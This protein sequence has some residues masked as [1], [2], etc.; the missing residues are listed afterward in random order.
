M[1]DN[2]FDN[3]RQNDEYELYSKRYTPGENGYTEQ[4][5]FYQGTEYQYN[6]VHQEKKN[7]KRLVA[8]TAVVIC[9]ALLCAGLVLCT[10]MIVSGYFNSELQ[11]ENI[12][13]D[14]VALGD[15]EAPESEKDDDWFF[16]LDDETGLTVSDSNG[17]ES[18][19]GKIGDE[20]LS[21]ADVVELVSASVVEIT[22]SEALKSG[23]VY[24]SGA[25]SGVIVTENGIIITNNHVVEGAAEISVRLSNGN[26]YKADLVAEA[27]AYLME[28]LGLSAD[29]VAALKVKLGPTT[30]H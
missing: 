17:K 18:V 13:Q 30:N 21:M 4:K 5:N 29:E 25:G 10:A 3:N 8:V 6:Y 19:S 2:G 14:N 20:N 7:R 22:T 26:V 23:L 27:E 24:S 1:N 11:V 12:V 15:S 9:A 16:G 28:D